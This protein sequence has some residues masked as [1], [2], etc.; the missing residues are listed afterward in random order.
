MNNFELMREYNSNEL[1]EKLSLLVNNCSPEL[2]K[3][4]ENA[5]FWLENVC[6]NDMNNNSFRALW[7]LL[8]CIADGE[9]GLDVPLF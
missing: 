8:E 7:H 5:L 4:A 9:N 6:K 2:A 3:N 1:F